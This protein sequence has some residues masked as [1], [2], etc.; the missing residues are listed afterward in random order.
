MEKAA[1][2]LRPALEATFPRFPGGGRRNPEV[3]NRPVDE[4]EGGRQVLPENGLDV[5]L[6]VEKPAAE[7]V[8]GRELDGVD[9]NPRYAKGPVGR[10]AVCEVQGSSRTPAHA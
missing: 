4:V 10:V 9:G 1:L 7:L 5:P 8:D 3:R 6:G 2:G